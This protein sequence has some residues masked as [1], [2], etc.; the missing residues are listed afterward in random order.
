M[1]CF[2]C[3]LCTA[4]QP[5]YGCEEEL[6]VP[7][8]L[9][10]GCCKVCVCNDLEIISLYALFRRCEDPAMWVPASFLSRLNTVAR[11]YELSV[12][13]ATVEAVLTSYCDVGFEF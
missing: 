5:V 8:A 7:A 2:A 9:F 10:T 3:R 1:G 6:L 13:N 11:W 4:S 12:D